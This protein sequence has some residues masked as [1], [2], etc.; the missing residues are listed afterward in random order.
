VATV[1]LG[2]FTG[3]P[4]ASTQLSTT[5]S[6]ITGLHVGPACALLCIIP[7]GKLSLN[8]NVTGPVST[9]VGDSTIRTLPLPVSDYT[10]TDPGVLRS[11]APVYTAKGIP[12]A[13]PVADNPQTVSAGGL[14]G[15]TLSSLLNTLGASLTVDKDTSQDTG[16]LNLLSSVLTSLANTLVSAVTSLLGPLLANVGGLVD[17]ILDPLLQILGLQVGKAT[18]IMDAVTVGQPYIVTTALP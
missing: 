7:L 11:S 6:P 3:S 9:T 18:V 5:K 16:L 12:P 15:S 4:T 10:L 17:V 2:T 1:S 14:L 8:V 13:T